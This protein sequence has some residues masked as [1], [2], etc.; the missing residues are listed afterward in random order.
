MAEVATIDF[1]GIQK[2]LKDVLYGKMLVYNK[3]KDIYEERIR[4]LLDEKVIAEILFAVST[5]VSKEIVLSNTN[6]NFVK[7]YSLKI[8]WALDNR[9]MELVHKKEISIAQKNLILTSIDTL[10]TAT[11]LRSI[12][13][14]ENQR[15]YDSQKQN[16]TVQP[17]IQ[18]K[19]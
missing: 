12:A 15:L 5:V 9:L 4:P 1:E 13:G 11:L 7:I 10:I 2:E 18:P 3:E 8:K 19:V 16:I 6:A 17:P 14:T